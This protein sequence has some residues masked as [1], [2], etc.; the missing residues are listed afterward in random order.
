MQPP[1]WQSSLCIRLWRLRGP[2]CTEIAPV[3][4][5]V[6]ISASFAMIVAK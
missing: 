6:L 2:F 4:R 3:S 1:A 5:S